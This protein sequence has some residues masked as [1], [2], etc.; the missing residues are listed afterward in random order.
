[1]HGNQS[2]TSTMRTPE[3]V[4]GSPSSEVGVNRCNSE[5]LPPRR[6]SS[7]GLKVKKGW[8]DG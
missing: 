4:P 1:M 7:H 8:F 6:E 2:L 5:K 3:T